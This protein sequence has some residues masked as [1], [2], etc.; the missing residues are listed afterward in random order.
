MQVVAI[1]MIILLLFL[2]SELKDGD[3]NVVKKMVAGR[4]EGTFGI[5]TSMNREK[6]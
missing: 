4:S 2:L 5:N 6:K 1:L 3:T